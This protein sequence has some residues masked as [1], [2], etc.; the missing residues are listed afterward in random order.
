[1][2][3]AQGRTHRGLLGPAVH[4]VLEVGHDS[5]LVAQ[6]DP[7]KNKTAESTRRQAEAA[8][9]RA[10]FI[11][12]PDAQRMLVFHRRGRTTGLE[13]RPPQLNTARGE[14]RITRLRRGTDHQKAAF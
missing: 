8:E 13:S 14:R 3:A 4:T 9:P 2:R 5:A 11:F 12:R 6:S 7:N 1:M 10:S